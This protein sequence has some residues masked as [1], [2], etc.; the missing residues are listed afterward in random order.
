MARAMN[1]NDLAW[2]GSAEQTVAIDAKFSPLTVIQENGSAGILETITAM[3]IYSGLSVEE[4]R[5]KDY[6]AGRK[7]I[8]SSGVNYLG[9][10]DP[11]SFSHGWSKLTT[12]EVGTATSNGARTS[13]GGYYKDNGIVKMFSLISLL[14]SSI[15]YS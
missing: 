12:F 9:V 14:K 7:P 13:S 10:A 1:G 5:V 6:E 8:P 4:L 15:R 2:A 3:E 11:Y